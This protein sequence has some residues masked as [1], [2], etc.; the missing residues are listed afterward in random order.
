[1]QN[2]QYVIQVQVPGTWSSVWYIEVHGVQGTVVP[3]TTKYLFYVVLVP[4]TSTSYIHVVVHV[5][6]T[7]LVQ[8]YPM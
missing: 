3:G 5:T 1:M 6:C 8:Q 7:W 2:I 4:F